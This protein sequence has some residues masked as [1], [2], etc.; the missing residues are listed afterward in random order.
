MCVHMRK[1]FES[2]RAHFITSVASRRSRQV[3]R[4]CPDGRTLQDWGQLRSD[5]VITP[6]LEAIAHKS[7]QSPNLPWRKQASLMC[8][9]AVKQI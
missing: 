8:C 7:V 6:I 4:R 3:Q 2:G 5:P 1:P 9:Q